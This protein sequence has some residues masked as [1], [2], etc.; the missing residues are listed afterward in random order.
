MPTLLQDEF[1]ITYL[2]DFSMVLEE[3]KEITVRMLLNY[4]TGFPR[5]DLRSGFTSTPFTGLAV[6]VLEDMKHLRFKHAP[7]Y[8]SVYSNDGFTIAI[9]SFP[10]PRRHASGLHGLQ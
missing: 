5:G 3:R 8:M 2:P 7:G 9:R 1:L 4:L 6:Q 10:M